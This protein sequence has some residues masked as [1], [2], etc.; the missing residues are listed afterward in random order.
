[1]VQLHNVIL[2]EFQFRCEDYFHVPKK[3]S[4]I[5]FYHLQQFIQMC[6]SY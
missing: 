6:H 2:R 5:H 4:T 1:M 3:Q